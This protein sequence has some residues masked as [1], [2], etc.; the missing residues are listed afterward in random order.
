MYNNFYTQWSFTVLILSSSVVSVRQLKGLITVFTNTSLT[1]LI[2]LCNWKRWNGYLC[3]SSQVPWSL[4]RIDKI[5]LLSRRDRCWQVHIVGGFFFVSGRVLIVYFIYF[6]F[7]WRSYLLKNWNA[8]QDKGPRFWAFFGSLSSAV[9]FFWRRY[10]L[11]SWNALRD[12]EK[13]PNNTK[14]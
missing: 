13:Q 3:P 7:D 4:T 1:V 11:K 12:K 10:L 14:V 2:K 5:S 8:L 9:L 6:V